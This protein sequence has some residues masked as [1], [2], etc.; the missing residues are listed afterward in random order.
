MLEGTR[1]DDRPLWPA[2]QESTLFILRGFPCGG[3][4]LSGSGVWCVGCWLHPALYS[5]QDGW[6][7]FFYL[8]TSEMEESFLTLGSFWDSS[9][10]RP[11]VQP[12]P[13]L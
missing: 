3:S 7:M 9:Q 2:S 4:D 8:G 1:F 12:T 6:N 13:W 10:S 5:G 11:E